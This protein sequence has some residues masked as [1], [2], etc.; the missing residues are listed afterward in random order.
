MLFLTIT[1]FNSLAAVLLCLAMTVTHLH[2][3]IKG[4]GEIKESAKFLVFPKVK[5]LENNGLKH[6]ELDPSCC[7]IGLKS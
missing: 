1:E 3:C 6:N 5:L 4:K 2:P 7:R